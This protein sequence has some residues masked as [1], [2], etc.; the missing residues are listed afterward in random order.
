MHICVTIE[1]AVT[2]ASYVYTTL[3]CYN[4]VSKLMAAVATAMLQILMTMVALL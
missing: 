4:R 3:H 2:I 1:L